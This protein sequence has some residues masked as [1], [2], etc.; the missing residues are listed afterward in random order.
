MD[1]SGLWIGYLCLAAVVFGGPALLKLY[2]V[3][4]RPGFVPLSNVAV[5]LCIFPALLA[6]WGYIHHHAC[7]WRWFWQLLFVVLTFENIRFFFTPKC[8]ETVAQLGRTRSW[9]IFG[10]VTLF[11]V[12]MFIALGIY[13]FGDDALWR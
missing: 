7:L 9:V 1:A 10:G 8:R 2:W 12:P 6:M 3:F 11:S 4:E 13:A 5:S